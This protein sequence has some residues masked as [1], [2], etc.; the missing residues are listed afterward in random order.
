MLKPCEAEPAAAAAARRLPMVET[1]S[2]PEDVEEPEPAFPFGPCVGPPGPPPPPPPP[3]VPVAPAVMAL[4][5]STQ[6]R[7]SI[8]RTGSCRGMVNILPPPALSVY[9]GNTSNRHLL[10]PYYIGA[11]GPPEEFQ[12]GISKP[13]LRDLFAPPRLEVLLHAAKKN[14]PQ[15]LGRAA[16]CEKK[17]VSG[18][19]S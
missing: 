2:S 12:H 8:G 18:S 13:A 1:E 6:A 17:R 4:V 5:C 11:F 15:L 10:A 16:S 19:A 7:G 14:S 3:M 9:V